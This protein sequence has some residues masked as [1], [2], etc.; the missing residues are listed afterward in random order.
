MRIFGKHIFR[1]IIKKPFQPLMI[2]LIIAIS[3]AVAIS[4]LILPIAI[5]RE[6]VAEYRVDEWTDDLT[7]TLRSNADVRLLF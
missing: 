2:I 5:Y 6:S 4:M 7:V 3:V 1:S